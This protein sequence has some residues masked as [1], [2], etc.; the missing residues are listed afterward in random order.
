DLSARQVADGQKVVEALGL[1]NVEL[2][3][4]SITDYAGF[5][6]FDYIVCHG[7]YSWV[8]AAVQDK[9]LEICATGLAPQGVAYVSYNTYPGWHTR[10]ML[11]DIMCSHAQRFAAPRERV[12][13]ARA[14]LDFLARSVPRQGGAYGV[15]LK[16]E[17]ELLRGK[18]D[19]YLLHEHLEEHNEP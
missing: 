1:T 17:V 6:A 4:L 10:G 15:L 2:K 11:C 7:V 13:Q 18:P 16:E 19:S 14:L 12:G 8:A 9:I 5:G 3:H